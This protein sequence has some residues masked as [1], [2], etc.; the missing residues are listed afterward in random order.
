MAA[1]Q[2]APPMKNATRI[3]LLLA[4]VA[5]IGDVML[6]QLPEKVLAELARP[7]A[8]NLVAH[9]PAAAAPLARTVALAVARTPEEIAGAGRIVTFSTQNLRTRLAFAGAN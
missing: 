5:L 4:A 1:S 7:H 2:I 9:S 3:A 6:R 8:R